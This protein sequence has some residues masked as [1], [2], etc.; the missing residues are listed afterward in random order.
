MVVNLGAL[1]GLK[2]ENGFK[3]QAQALKYGPAFRYRGD[4]NKICGLLS[5]KFSTLK[6]DRNGQDSKGRMERTL[7]MVTLTETLLQK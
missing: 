5:L 7:R 2:L 3:F 6:T 4:R 1:N